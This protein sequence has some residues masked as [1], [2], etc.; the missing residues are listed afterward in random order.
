MGM[1]GAGGVNRSFLA[2]MPIVLARM[3]PVKA[4]SFRVARRIANAFRAGDAVTGYAALA[5]C[6]L[7]WI[8]VPDAGLDRVS[9]DLAAATP[10][11]GKLAVI[12][13]S[14][15][16]SSWPAILRIVPSFS[17]RVSSSTL[18]SLWSWG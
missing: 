3:G 2:R 5:S 6:D 15:R 9:R 4:A 12:C 17:C 14:A 1:I 16:D 18:T 10:L 8:V 11:T 13:G 7:I